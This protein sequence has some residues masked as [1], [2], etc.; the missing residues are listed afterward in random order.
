[1]AKQGLRGGADLING[2]L[3]G[4]L[5]RRFHEVAAAF[6]AGMVCSHTAVRAKDATVRVN[7]GTSSAASRRRDRRGDAAPR[8]ALA[9]GVAVTRLLI[10]PTHD[11]ARNTIT[12]SSC[13]ATEKNLVK[14]GGLSSG[15]SAKKISSGR[16][17]VWV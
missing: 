9:V 8:H 2:H 13:C 15:L 10:D 12:P 17:W 6:G 5:T 16:L 3:G 11:S 1:V 4:H 7:Y 14:T